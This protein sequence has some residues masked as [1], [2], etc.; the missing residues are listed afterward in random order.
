MKKCFDHQKYI[1]KH[2]P[3]HTWIVNTKLSLRR[4]NFSS[5]YR[6]WS[7]RSPAC[8][9]R[10]AHRCCSTVMWPTY[11]PVKAHRSILITIAATTHMQ[12]PIYLEHL[13]LLRILHLSLNTFLQIVT[14][15]NSKVCRSASHRFTHHVIL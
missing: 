6:H 5:V 10:P 1:H 9:H 13:R 3:I 8:E 12:E 2:M 14:A 7:S 15:R 4:L 11:T